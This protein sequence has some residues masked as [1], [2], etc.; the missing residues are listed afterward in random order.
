MNMQP[1]RIAPHVLDIPDPNTASLDRFNSICG[2]SEVETNI[3]KSEEP[4]SARIGDAVMR[5]VSSNMIFSPP[6]RLATRLRKQLSIYDDIGHEFI[7]CYSGNAAALTAI[8]QTYLGRDIEA[9][10]IAHAEDTVMRTAMATGANI[11]YTEHENPFEPRVD[12]IIRSMSPKTRIVFMANPTWPTGA[13]W[14]AAELIFLLSY[15]QNTMFVVDESYFEFSGVTM[16]P[17]VD[18][19]PNLAVIRSL[20]PAI[21]LAGADL[22]YVISDCINWQYIDRIGIGFYPNS[23]AQAAFEAVL[24]DLHFV[25]RRIE[26]IRLANKLLADKLTT[27]GYKVIETPCD[28]LLV[29]IDSLDALRHELPA[30]S[31]RYRKLDEIEGLERYLIVQSTCEIETAA[32]PIVI[33]SKRTY[34]L[35]TTERLSRSNL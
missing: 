12:E 3:G 6:D 21:G 29:E 32:I 14:S 13:I 20:S 19:F 26:S 18:K 27:A 9:V 10:I 11:R 34:N 24:N 7:R 33:D 5:L 25:K 8:F 28:Y 2:K 1:V 16:L 31:F 35:L 30:D 17:L 4:L 22:S 23:F 15:G